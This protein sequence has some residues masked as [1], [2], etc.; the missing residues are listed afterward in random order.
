MQADPD[1]RF[2]IT[3]DV[4]FPNNGGGWTHPFANGSADITIDL[5][6][7]NSSD[8]QCKSGQ[9][10]NY[11]PQSYDALLAHELGHAYGYGYSSQPNGAGHSLSVG[12]MPFGMRAA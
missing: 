9:P 8:A 4:L 11:Y 7:A 6:Y 1:R 12:K 5:S 2:V 10:S 3:D